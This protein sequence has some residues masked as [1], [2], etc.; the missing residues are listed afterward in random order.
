MANTPYPTKAELQAQLAQTIASDN[1]FT[2]S[3]VLKDI[4]KKENPAKPTN[5]II[6][7]ISD[8]GATANDDWY[9]PVL[10]SKGVKGTFAIIS[11]WMGDTGYMTAT[12][13]KELYEAGHDI[14]GHT[15][16]H[17]HFFNI[18]EAQIEQEV[19][20]CKH[21]LL[22]IG[23]DADM[24]VI[25]Y[26]ERSEPADAII[27]KYFK[28]DFITG[29]DADVTNGI[30]PNLPPL[31]PFY[32]KRTSFDAQANGVSKITILKQAVDSVVASGGWLN[33]AIH[34]QYAEYSATSNPS[35]YAARRAE[36]GELIDYIQSLN[37][38]ILTATQAYSI[39]KN[40]VQIGHTRI[41]TKFYALGMDHSET[42]NYFG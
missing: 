32:I 10:D 37:V 15:E 4:W 17:A 19:Y 13:V 6:S 23:I 21:Q 1:N 30:A 8:D 39:Y 12:R 18:T 38:P 5:P 40:P 33:F 28:N 29:P 16:T 14:A 3:T 31:D 9:I 26:G 25:P 2:V 11:G 34:P 20:N 36:L 35:G 41:D 24:F 42:G 7:F 27:R 22:K